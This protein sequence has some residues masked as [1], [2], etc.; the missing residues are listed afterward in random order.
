[1]L[2]RLAGSSLNMRSRDAS[3][4][5]RFDGDDPDDIVELRV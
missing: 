2:P 4:V 1:M 5:S 3:K